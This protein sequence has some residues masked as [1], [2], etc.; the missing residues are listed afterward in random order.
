MLADPTAG[1]QQVAEA[2]QAVQT[3][4]QQA[5][6]ELAAEGQRVEQAAVVV[7]HRPA[8]AWAAG[9]AWAAER[10]NHH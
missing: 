5:A 6:V 9:A 2:E 4:M 3:E 8:A 7:L 1:N 10:H